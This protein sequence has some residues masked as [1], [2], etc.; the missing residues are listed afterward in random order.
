MLRELGMTRVNLVGACFG[1]AISVRLAQRRPE[2]LNRLVLVG[3]TPRVP[4]DYTECVRRW[5]TMVANGEK[6]RIADELVE[7]FVA[8][9]DVP[10]LRNLQRYGDALKLAGV[11]PEDLA[12][13]VDFLTAALYADDPEMG[14]YQLL[15]S[16]EPFR[17][18]F[19]GRRWQGIE[20]FLPKISHRLIRR[21]LF[22]RSPG[23]QLRLN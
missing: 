10:C 11:G 18:R 4:D 14:G 2:V 15:I 19:R 23:R 12:H 22:F 17:A 8:N 13:I 5:T 20:V 6:T 3:M 16:G 7:R 1:G 9:P 21:R